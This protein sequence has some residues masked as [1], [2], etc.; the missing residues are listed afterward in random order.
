MTPLYLNNSFCLLVCCTSTL[1]YIQSGKITPVSFLSLQVVFQITPLS[2]AQW[3]VVMKFSLPVILLD[4]LLKFVARNYADGKEGKSIKWFEL[5][6]ILAVM[7]AYGYG[8]YLD[9][10][11]IMGMGKGA[12]KAL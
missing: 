7:V 3:M 5:F 4:E 8:W 6:A 2:W 1:L 11:R 10:L 12:G 9:E